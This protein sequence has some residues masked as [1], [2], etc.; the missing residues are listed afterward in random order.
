PELSDIVGKGLMQ[1]PE[2]RPES[3]LALRER[4]EEI[5][6]NALV[7]SVIEDGKKTSKR[8]DVITS[9]DNVITSPNVRKDYK[10][11]PAL[12]AG[13]GSTRSVPKSSSSKVRA[14]STDK[15][16]ESETV[17]ISSRKKSMVLP[18]ILAAVLIGGGTTAWLLY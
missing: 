12:R 14:G 9:P 4:L 11:D 2:D 5:E 16:V 17:Q 8:G 1:A 6:R 10:T 13:T 7:E 3:A 15:P 18:I